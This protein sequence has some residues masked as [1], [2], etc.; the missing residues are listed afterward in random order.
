M[1]A[2]EGSEE[3]GGLPRWM[4]LRAAA[5]AGRIFALAVLGFGFFDAY[6][7]LILS[8]QIDAAVQ[9]GKPRDDGAFAGVREELRK[10]AAEEGTSLEWRAA[11]SKLVASVAFALLLFVVSECAAVLVAMEQ[12]NRNVAEKLKQRRQPSI[13]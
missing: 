1:Q 12:A 3:N 7:A 5:M 9:M 2:K 10:Q 4:V 6:S 8:K 11:I 13:V